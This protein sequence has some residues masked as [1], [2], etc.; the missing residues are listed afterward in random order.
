VERDGINW[1]GIGLRAAALVVTIS[2]LTWCSMAR[3][4]TQD[5]AGLGPELREMMLM[6]GMADASGMI[7]IDKTAKRVGAVGLNRLL[8]DNAG[9]GSLPALRWIANHGAEPRNVGALDKG[10]LLQQ[11]IDSQAAKDAGISAPYAG[12]P[13]SMSV[14]QALRPYPQYLSVQSLFAGWGKSWYDALQM[15]LERRFGSAQIVANYTWSKSLGMGHYRQVFGQ[16]GSPGATPQDYYNLDDSKVHEVKLACMSGEK[17]CYGGW[18]T[19]NAKL[20]W[21]RGAENKHRCDTCCYT[22]NNNMTP[23][24]NLNN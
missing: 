10:T 17:I 11:R 23:V 5:V 21:G 20:Y 14:A 16:V 12:F 18:A 7:D 22:C 13:G 19:G 2:L 3:R 15:K 8:Y 4:S 9:T 24:I 1:L 6:N